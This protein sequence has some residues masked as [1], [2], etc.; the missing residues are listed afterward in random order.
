MSQTIGEVVDAHVATRGDELALVGP[1]F[2]GTRRLTW[3]ELRDEG[4]ALAR[5][6]VRAG[7]GRGDRVAAL[8][9]NRPEWVVTALAA[10]RIG[11]TLVPLN[12]WYKPA[13]LA[14]TLSRTGAVVLLSEAG[15]LKR[16]FASDIAS[17]D[18]GIAA[19]TPGE[20]R[21]EA[22]PQLRTVVHPEARSGAFGW[23]EFVARGSGVVLDGPARPE[24]P[25]FLLYTS[26]ST[27][28]PKGVVLNQGPLLQNGTGI[29][30]RRGIDSSDRIWLGSP[31][32]YGLGAANCLPA[33][34][35]HGA[36]LVLQGV[37]TA[38]TALDVIERERC[39]V[40]YGMSNMVLAIHESPV[41]SR[42]RVSSLVK[43]AAG[44]SVAERKILIEDMGVSGATASYGATELY[45]N[46]FGGNPD[47]PLDLKY[48]TTGYPLP[49]FEFRIVDPASL[50]DLD[51]GE[52]GLL[53]VRGFVIDAYDG[54]P[55][56]T[57]SAFVGDGW[58]STGDLGAFGA[59][60]YF[61]YHSRMKEMIKVGGINVSPV[62]VEQILLRHP[63][64]REASV[65][66][67]PDAVRGEAMVA[68]LAV[69]GGLEADEVRGYMRDTAAAFKTPSRFLIRGSDWVPRTASGKV[70]KA[71][72]RE[73]VLTALAEDDPAGGATGAPG[74]VQGDRAS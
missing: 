40:F 42:E 22:F 52:V 43:G 72:L 66:G 33:W 37:F 48:E 32:F 20:L 63:G 8:L 67:V 24:D 16:D 49:G 38:E 39:T 30:D 11:A 51:P 41:Y 64:I 2:A 35:T 58:Y 54:D 62:E 57:R 70:A 28:E 1:G 27:A 69:A 45:G 10:G 47:D 3:R 26:G 71:I 68:V 23:D 29:G 53:L 5:A 59:D 18:P 46:C 13:E 7:V 6:L 56:D 25:L 65:V 17:L 31:L 60:G 73:K 12:T 9:G 61:R 14:W 15:F 34:L 74:E 36:C 50:E 55:P 4:A 19:G 21:L 44:I